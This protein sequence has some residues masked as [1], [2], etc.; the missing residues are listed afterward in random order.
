MEPGHG[1]WDGP[2][3]RRIA[4]SG[5]LFHLLLAAWDF[6]RE[7]RR[8]SRVARAASDGIVERFVDEAPTWPS[9][10]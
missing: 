7:K 1:A 9:P 8:S 2:Q 3:N 6:L 4:R 10:T 5:P